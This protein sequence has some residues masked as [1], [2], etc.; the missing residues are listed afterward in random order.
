MANCLW[1]FVVLALFV[2][3]ASHYSSAA[4]IVEERETEAV[5]KLE[6]IESVARNFY[7]NPALLALGSKSKQGQGSP[8]RETQI[9]CSARNLF[10][11]VH[12]VMFFPIFDIFL[13][14]YGRTDQ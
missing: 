9:I 5:D 13:Q 11:R 7:S 6:P 8:G 12:E 10:Y 3:A 14:I 1:R 2:V 4:S